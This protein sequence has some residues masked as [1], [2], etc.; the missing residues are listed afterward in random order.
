[1][2]FI[3]LSTNTEDDDFVFLLKN[4]V[5]YHLNTPLH[6]SFLKKRERDKFEVKGEDRKQ[7]HLS[8]QCE[9]MELTFYFYYS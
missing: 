1:M 9:H 4:I 7:F 3:L 8:L 5:I 2:N 6:D